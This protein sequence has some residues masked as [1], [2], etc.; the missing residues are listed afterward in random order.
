LSSAID[1]LRAR[2][3]GDTA[4]IRFADIATTRLTDL[5]A[6]VDAT[7]SMPPGTRG[8]ALRAVNSDLDRVD[9]ELMTF[10]VGPRSS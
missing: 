9:A 8:A 2:R 3:S 5:T 10:L 6:A 4:V 1:E 7:V